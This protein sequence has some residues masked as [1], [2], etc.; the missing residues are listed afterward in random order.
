MLKKRL[1]QVSDIVEEKSLID[2]GSDHGYLLIDLVD[3]KRIIRG[4]AV[5]ITDGPLD[6]VITNVKNNRLEDKINS[7]KSD[8]L[9]QIESEIADRFEAISICG[10]GG[11]LIVKI[12]ADSIDKIEGKTLYLQPNNSEPFLRL[13]LQN[14]GYKIIE[15]Y[16]IEDN[17]IYYEII[18]AIPG[19]EVL[20]KDQVYFGPY[21]LMNKSLN[22]I[23]KYN[24]KYNHL[25]T[26][27]EELSQKNIKNQ[28]IIDE[29]NMIREAIYETI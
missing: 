28:R 2:I 11:N 9:L 29:I 16:I 27:N 1:K 20:N 5:E 13:Q 3:K 26:I 18:K 19:S 12:I 15:E 25:I 10:M 23:N 24:E 8:G 17:G 22:F 7:L 4:L 21:I 14:L 6:N